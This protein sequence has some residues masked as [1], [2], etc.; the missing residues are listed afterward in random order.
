M[1]KNEYLFTKYNG[2]KVKQNHSFWQLTK[3]IDIN[4]ISLQEIGSIAITEKVVSFYW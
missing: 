2:A 4:I 3:A 1:D